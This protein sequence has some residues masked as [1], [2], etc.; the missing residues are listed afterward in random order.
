M[1]RFLLTVVLGIILVGSSLAESRDYSGCEWVPGRLIVDFTEEV[2]TLYEKESAD[3]SPIAIG[4]P[5]VDELLRQYK[6]TLMYRIADDLMLS[7]IRIQPDFYRLVVL[8][9]PEDIDVMQMMHDFDASTHVAATWPDLLHKVF[10]TE[11]NDP[12]WGAQWDKR[13]MGIPRVWDFST[14]SR[15]IQVIAIDGGTCFQHPDFFDN[16]WVNPGE[17]IDGDGVPWTWEDYPGDTDDLNGVDDDLNG[18]EDDFIAWDFIRNIGGCVEQD[19]CDNFED[20]DP[21]AYGDHGT[22]VLGL[23]GEVGNN[24]IGATGVNWNIL[25]MASRAGYTRAADDQGLVVS[26]AAVSCITWALGHGVDVLNMSYGSPGQGLEGSV[27]NTAW[28]NGCILTAA[29]GN[30]YGV[31]TPQYPAAFEPVI[32]V[33]STSNQQNCSLVSDFSNYGTWVECFAPGDDVFSTLCPPNDDPPPVNNPSYGINGGTSMA[34]PNTGG[35]CALLW[36]VFP[37]YT[38]QQIKD[39]LEMGCVDISAENTDINSSYLGW[40]KVDAEN[41]LRQ[42]LPYLTVTGIWVEGDNDDDG[43]LERFE[44][45][46]LYISVNNEAGWSTGQSVQVSVSA[47]Y[48]GNLSFQNSSFLLGTINAGQTVTNTAHPVQIT[49]GWFQDPYWATLTFQFTGANGLNLTQTATLRVGRP[50]VLVV[51]DDAGMAYADF[52][53]T[54]LDGYDPNWRV[55]HDVWDTNLDAAISYADI[56]EYDHIIWA[57]GNATSNTLT[58]S[59]M[60]ALASFMDAGGNVMIASQG[61]DNDATVTGNSF[62]ANYMHAQATTTAGSPQLVG[63]TDDPISDG[64][65]LGLVGGG[66]GGNNVSASVLTPANDGIGIY[67]YSGNENIGAIRYAGNGYKMVYFGFALEAACGLVPNTQH[68][69][70]VVKAVAEWFD[71]VIID[72]DEPAAF[73]LPSEF[74]L[75]PNYPNPFNP[76]TMIS[77]DVGT[78]SRVVIRV[79]D[80]LG[81]EVSKLVDRRLSPGTHSVSFSGANLASGI[82]LVNMQADGFSATHRMVLMK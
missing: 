69:S 76:E 20:N 39:L 64:T 3:G 12:N 55:L 42:V 52:F 21:T 10:D 25:I 48:D 45:G 73:T 60:A 78:H 1:N 57:T 38:N 34:A 18:K 28:A 23:M 14:G 70:V 80:L 67:K 7:K 49:S 74:A 54:A 40:G 71:M 44:T 47:P 51:D 82:Y 30:D 32:A 5:A 59:D 56:S 68:Y 15:E 72:V 33:G 36:S 66:C 11:P 62:Y 9:G 19:D 43:R 63:V 4:V 37:D 81:R 29:A 24:G 65:A 13:C 79:Y 17:D 8:Q 31:T 2:G 35:V 50:K 58:A 61:A 41:S 75:H 6:I 26:S 27:I 77:F 46:S 22:H 53:S 16:L